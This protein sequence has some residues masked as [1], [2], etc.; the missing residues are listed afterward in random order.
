MPTSISKTAVDGTLRTNV[1]EMLNLTANP[2]FVKINDR[3]YGCILT[4]TNGVERYVRLG[5]IVAEIKE[6][7]SAR[8]YME[9]EIHDYEEKQANKAARAAERQAK[10]EADRIAREE[11]KKKAEQPAD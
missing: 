1:F 9:K 11:K 10:A 8:E 3:S 4:D 5:A 2:N 6:D 7:M